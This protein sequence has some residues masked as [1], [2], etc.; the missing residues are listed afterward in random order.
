MIPIIIS[1]DCTDYDPIDSWVFHDPRRVDFW[2][3]FV[4]GPDQKGGDS[5]QLNVL[6]TKMAQSKKP[7]AN[8]IMLDSYSWNA[9]LLKVNEILKQCS[10]ENWDVV[11]SK[12]S[13]HMAWE[14]EDYKVYKPI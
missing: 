5:F 1:F 13:K 12:L 2:V 7:I 10:G 4:I 3:N 14:F 8:T 11:S 6:T 9:V